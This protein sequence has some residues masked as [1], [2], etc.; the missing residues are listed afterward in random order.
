VREWY[1]LPW[2]LALQRVRALSQFSSAEALIDPDI[3]LPKS[4]LDYE[5][6]RD[7][8]HRDR[9]WRLFVF[10]VRDLQEATGHPH[11][12]RFKV[13]AGSLYDTAYCY[14]FTYCPFPV[15][16]VGGFESAAPIEENNVSVFEAWREMVTRHGPGETEQPMGWLVS[17]V[18]RIMISDIA[19]RYGLS[20]F[21]LD[22]PKPSDARV[23]D[24][25]VPETPI[26]SRHPTSRVDDIFSAK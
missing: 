19:S 11:V 25:S 24:P 15:V 5:D 22:R 9:R 20:P 12:G 17:G 8:G 2:A 18:N 6:W 23:K 13:A 7:R 21:S 10:E 26:G 14:N 16:L 4:Q 3:K 1:D